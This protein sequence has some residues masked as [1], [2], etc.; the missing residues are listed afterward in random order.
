[1]K[2]ILSFIIAFA[3]IISMSSVALAADMNAADFQNAINEAAAGGGTY[4]LTG[5]VNITGSGDVTI[6][7][8]GVEIDSGTYSI[9]IT[10]DADVTVTG[11]GSISGSGHIFKLGKKGEA[12]TGATLTIESGVSVSSSDGWCVALYSD[13]TLNTSG[14]LRADGGYAPVLNSG[15]DVY[16][17]TTINVMGGSITHPSDLAIYNP[18]NG[19][20]NVSGGTI[21]GA[22]GIEM[23]R[24]TLNVTGGTITATGDYIEPHANNSGSTLT[25][26]VA[27]AVSEHLTN[28][29]ISVNITGGTLNATGTDGKALYAYDVE[30][31]IEG[32]ASTLKIEDGTFNAPVVVEPSAHLDDDGFISG[33]IFSKDP[34]EYVAKNTPISKVTD[35]SGNTIYAVGE[36]ATKAAATPGST[37]EV[38]KGSVTLNDGT[39]INEGESHIVPKPSSGNGIKVKYEGGNSFSTSKSAV[40]TSVEIDGVAVG[41]T[42]D[43]KLF[44]V[45]SIPAGAKWVTVRWNSTSVT[46]NFT[47]SGAYAAQV[48]IPKTG[49]M[50]LRAAVL[51]VFGF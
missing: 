50:P 18:G 30:N 44:T 25:S 19:V 42:G 12:N 5:N 45:N 27:V 28:E 4:A 41:F 24:G 10:N 26:G 38:I 16:G 46:T 31:T 33:G 39:T 1:M 15:G 48:E 17:N 37:V 2:K 51:A 36:K 47:P 7:L 22:A 34:S 23:R 11:G 14:T 43:G 8:K 35:A 40:P 9:I 29:K 32:E 6:D 21:T 20:V 13:S 3:M 49:D